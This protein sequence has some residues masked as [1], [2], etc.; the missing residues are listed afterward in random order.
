M[1]R[2]EQEKSRL[3]LSGLLL[4]L[5]WMSYNHA[6][7]TT[8]VL[9]T[10]TMMTTAGHQLKLLIDNYTLRTNK[11]HRLKQY[12][13]CQERKLSERLI[14]MI[15]ITHSVLQFSLKQIYNVSESLSDENVSLSFPSRKH[16]ALFPCYSS[17]SQAQHASF[18]LLADDKA[19]ARRLVEAEERQQGSSFILV[20]R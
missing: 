14:T 3:Q 18:Y 2:I 15:H 1:N 13:N 6:T 20:P 5:R 7:T 16:L 19:A 9:F 11:N 17:P 4:I 10:A 12:H 8:T